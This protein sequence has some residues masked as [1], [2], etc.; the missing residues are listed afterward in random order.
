MG[1]HKAIVLTVSMLAG[2]MLGGRQADAQTFQTYRCA[3]G[4]QF[5]V[6]FYDGDKRAFLQIDGEPVAL[7][8]RLAVSGARYSGAGVTLRIPKSG[9]TTVKHLKRPVTACAVVE[10]PGI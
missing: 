4:T 8:K 2:G 5:I 9:P 6:G 3:D 10:K 7:A 1:R